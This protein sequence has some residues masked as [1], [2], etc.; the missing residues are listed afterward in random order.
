MKRILNISNTHTLH[1]HKTM[2]E[3]ELHSIILMK[4]MGKGRPTKITAPSAEAPTKQRHQQ[5]METY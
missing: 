2:L 1:A 5:R 3:N 4:S